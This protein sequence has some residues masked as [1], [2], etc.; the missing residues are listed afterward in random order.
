MNNEELYALKKEKKYNE[1][2]DDN[3]SEKN[4]D[5]EKVNYA[6]LFEKYK[7]IIY[8]AL[9]YSFGLFIGAYFYKTASNETLDELLKPES[10]TVLSLF[11]SDF[12]VYFSLFMLVVFLGFCLI[13]YPI[14]NIIPMVIGIV[15]G[16][17]T[18]FLYINYSV[19]GVGYSL[20]MLVPYAALFLTV[21]SFTIK[22]SAELSKQIVGIT[23]NASENTEFSLKPYI[24][25]Y[26]LL[27]L[28]I[29]VTAL[30]DAGLTSLLFTVVTI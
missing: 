20:V 18:A 5:T 22:L 1:K 4:N 21:I 14:I 2:T 19:K 11:I 30:I 12:C 13:G 25:K 8:T 28:C 6:V 10:R 26:L 27:A 7:P 17:R 29:A 24:K 23:K 16:I 3:S 9:F 15:T